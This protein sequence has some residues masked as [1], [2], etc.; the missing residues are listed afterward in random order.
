MIGGAAGIGGHLEI[1][2]DV[3]VTGMAMVSHSILQ[4][5]VYSSL[6]PIEPLRRWKRVVAR[7]K[8]MADREAR[9]ARAAPGR[10]LQGGA[11][12]SQ[13]GSEGGTDSQD[14]QRSRDDE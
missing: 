11:Q 13:A 5:G 7:L 4:P 2:D 12:A 1:C 6:I 8:L 3:V 9:G 14:L 10:D